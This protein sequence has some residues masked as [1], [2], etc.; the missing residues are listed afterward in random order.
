MNIERSE[1][2]RVFFLA[3]EDQQ[4]KDNN[5]MEEMMDRNKF[6][7]ESIVSYERNY[8]RQKKKQADR[9]LRLVREE[10]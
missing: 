2:R 6:V 8:E 10:E 7:K 5:L 9:K 4:R 3:L 1:Y